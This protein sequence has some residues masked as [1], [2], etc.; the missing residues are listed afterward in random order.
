MTKRNGSKATKTPREALRASVSRLGT[1]LNR[2][3]PKFAKL[4][5]T[6]GAAVIHTKEDADRLL[7]DI[8]DRI[9]SLPVDWKPVAG[10]RG[11]PAVIFA[12]GDTVQIRE[13]HQP[14]YKDLLGKTVTDKFV[15]D[16]VAGGLVGI[17]RTGGAG[18]AGLATLYIPK[19]HLRKVAA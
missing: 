6:I 7:K 14:L 5:P 10:K 4:P 13:K 1:R 15:V 16:N 17:H 19:N 8:E 11:R 3:M 12:T 2:L 9:A 18:S